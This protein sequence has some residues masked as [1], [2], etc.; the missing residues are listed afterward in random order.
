MNKKAIRTL[1]T[2]SL[3]AALALTAAGCATVSPY[4]AAPMKQETTGTPSG[5]EIRAAQV[6]GY[7]LA[8]YLL[9][10]GADA[11]PK[12][13]HLMVFVTTSEGK[14][15]ADAAVT[16]TLT[17]PGTEERTVTASHIKGGT[18]T[19][20]VGPEKHTAKTVPMAGGYGAD[21][22]LR[23]KGDYKIMTKVTVGATST[24]DAFAYTVK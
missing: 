5:D 20:K 17:G 13:K 9:D 18:F 6:P 12:T 2:L 24:T 15:V 23:E 7:Q 1:T 16:Y 14:D 8:Y 11:A 21:V 4:A 22:Y 10:L 3:G 19:Y